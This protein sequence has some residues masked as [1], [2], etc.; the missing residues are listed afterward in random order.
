M[1][2]LTWLEYQ[3]FHETQDINH[4]RRKD[5]TSFSSIKH[6]PIAATIN[7]DRNKELYQTLKG[8][9]AYFLATREESNRTDTIIN[10][11]REK[12]LE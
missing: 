5:L 6:D 3:D 2:K 12:M 10:L 7:L 4:I 1:L 9:R 8:D 11:E